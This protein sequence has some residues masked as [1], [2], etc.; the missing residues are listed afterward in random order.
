MLTQL[1]SPFTSIFSVL[2]LLKS[3]R[4]I[5]VTAFGSSS[6]LYVSLSRSQ[7]NLLLSPILYPQARTILGAKGALQ[8]RDGFHPWTMGLMAP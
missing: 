2:F 1:V 6:K 7:N 8:V 5:N 3:L 4:S